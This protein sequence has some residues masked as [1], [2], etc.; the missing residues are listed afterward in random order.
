MLTQSQLDQI[1]EAVSLAEGDIKYISRELEILRFQLD[2]PEMMTTVDEIEFL[3]EY[4]KQLLD[5][6]YS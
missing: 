5:E 6:L 2:H 4:Q 3:E 1:K